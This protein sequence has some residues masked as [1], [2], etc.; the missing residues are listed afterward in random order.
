M[1][2]PNVNIVTFSSC[3][4]LLIFRISS[5][6]ADC[7]AVPHCIQSVWIHKTLP[8]DNSEVCQTCLDMV[9]QARDQL[10]SNDTQEL[11]KEV[12]EGS[13]DLLHVKPIVKECIKIADNYIPELVDTLASQMNPQVVCH[14]AGLCNNERIHKLALEK[15]AILK[16]DTC[17]GCHTVVD[18]MQSKLKQAS[19]DDVLEGFL[20]VH[21]IKKTRKN[22]SLFFISLLLGVRQVGQLLRRVQQ[23]NRHIFQRYLHIFTSELQ[24]E[25]CVSDGGRMFRPIPHSCRDYT[26]IAHRLCPGE[27]KLAKITRFPPHF[28]DFFVRSG[29]DL[30]CEL[31]EQL[32][33]HLRELL[34]ANTTE[35]E[36]KQVLQG[37]CKQTKSFKDQCLDLVDEYYSVAYNFL[38]SELNSTVACGI[39]GICPANVKVI[40]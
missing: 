40:N 27:V 26:K 1:P 36:F 6:A 23:H 4:L 34:I 9:K 37:L 7:H 29:D 3:H 33:Q 10:L 5:A 30:P 39:I 20:M 14:V 17:E 18:V 31:C 21:E 12:F 11:I 13:C 28:N 38:L 32:V 22:R 8:P 16:Q 15:T 35:M 25:R 2:K 24:F 19:K